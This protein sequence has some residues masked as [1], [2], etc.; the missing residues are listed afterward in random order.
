M[1]IFEEQEA[2][3]IRHQTELEAHWQLQ[4]RELV[5]QVPVVGPLITYIRQQIS[6]I[7]THWLLKPLVKQQN[8]FN[9]LI[10]QSLPQFWPAIAYQHTRYAA[11]EQE[12]SELV[13]DMAEVMAQLNQLQKRLVDLENRL[14]QLEK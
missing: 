5:S 13:H 4:Q 7:S 1:P 10:T 8:E 11:L 14:Q 9:Y 3:F 6:K 12:E 2:P